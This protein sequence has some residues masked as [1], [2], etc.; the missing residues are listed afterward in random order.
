MSL[1]LRRGSTAAREAATFQVGE[2]IWD[3]SESALYIGDG[4]G[5][6]MGGVAV[7]TSSTG[8]GELY[9]QNAQMQTEDVT[10]LAG[11]N[12]SATG[13]ITIVLP[14]TMTIAPGSRVV[15]I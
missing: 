14:A 4:I 9:R 5:N 3:E 2:P 8:G 10:I 7:G 13:P 15:I 6:T 11:N 12:A 1:R